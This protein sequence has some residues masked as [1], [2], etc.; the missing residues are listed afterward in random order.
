MK[1]LVMKTIKANNAKW[2]KR[3]RKKV[4]GQNKAF[5]K[6]SKAEKRVLIAKDVISLLALDAIFPTNGVY[7]KVEKEAGEFKV[8]ENDEIQKIFANPLSRSFPACEVCAIGAAMLSTIRMADK[9]KVKDVVVGCSNS[10]SVIDHETG[11][12]S[13]DDRITGSSEFS[14]EYDDD[15]S[16]W[17][18]IFGYQMLAEM[19]KTFEHN[20]CN[21]Y[22]DVRDPNLVMFLVYENIVMNKGK[23]IPPKNPDWKSG[24]CAGPHYADH[25]SER[26]ALF[27][28]DFKKDTEKRFKE[29]MKVSKKKS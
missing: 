6:A 21:M 25:V 18:N 5:A 23:Y 16:P 10:S 14:L 7:F 29:L 26:E 8:K 9:L 20:H 13:L 12:E 19:E 28:K 15:D 17:V 24:C 4:E 11:E 3:A 2:L 1:E 27:F 22:S